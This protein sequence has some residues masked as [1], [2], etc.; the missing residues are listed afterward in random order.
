MRAA[1]PPKTML[2]TYQTTRWRV[3]EDCHLQITGW[4]NLK[5]HAGL[6]GSTLLAVSHNVNVLEHRCEK[7]KSR[8]LNEIWF[9][10]ASLKAVDILQIFYVQLSFFL[11]T[12][13]ETFS[14][15]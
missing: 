4:E 13:H 9:R 11:L 8:N 15:K 12:L 14:A 6:L 1:F 2:P 7:F 5:S 3:A 10:K